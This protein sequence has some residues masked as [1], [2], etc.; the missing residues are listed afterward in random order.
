MPSLCE[1]Q[2]RFA[3]ALLAA[4]GT[5]PGVAVAGV[6]NGAER[7]GIYRRTIR[8]N[9]RNA[10]AATYA[11]VLRLV[12]TPFFH[13]AVDAYVE[14][15][16]SRSGDLN[17]YGATF[18][19]FLAGYG[20][21]SRL[22]YLP[23]IARLEWAIDESNRA[24]DSDAIPDDVLRALAAVPAE[25]LPTLCL[26]LDPSCRLITS[27]YPL[28]RI[29]QVNQ[30]DFRGDLQVDFDAAPDR[31]RIWRE[32]DGVALERLGAGDF[33][34][35]GALMEGAALARAIEGALAADAAFDLG[36]ALHR[37]VGDGTITK[38]LD[39]H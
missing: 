39:G 37:F 20:P 5:A 21:A 38:T 29:W 10:L 8:S 12:D 33:A 4:D 35:L 24:A 31:L 7:I 13:G 28:L 6:A 32:S 19:D 30:P 34:W 23:D 16:P 27:P 1:L 17:E 9:Y 36:S 2:R 18:G 15:H 14:A 11:V 3:A 25:R 26:R 22:R